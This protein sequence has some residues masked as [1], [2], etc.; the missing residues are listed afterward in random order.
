[1]PTAHGVTLR[2]V[3]TDRG[4]TIVPGATDVVVA[5]DFILSGDPSRHNASIVRGAALEWNVQLQRL[6][7]LFRPEE[8]GA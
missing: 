8:V 6:R 7:S 2:E 3:L 5:G 1:V 4:E